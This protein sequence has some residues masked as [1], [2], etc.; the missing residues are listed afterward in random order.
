LQALLP[1]RIRLKCLEVGAGLEK[2]EE[3]ALLDRKVFERAPVA[4]IRHALKYLQD[5]YGGPRV[6]LDT[7]GFTYKQQDKLR[8]AI[9]DV[10]V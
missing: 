7:I 10:H 3:F 1:T 4:A 9:L 5:R 8:Q 6:Y 2:R